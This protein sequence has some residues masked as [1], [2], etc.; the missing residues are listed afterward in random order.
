MDIA[1]AT[2]SAQKAD[3]NHST[4]P[5]HPSRAAQKESDLVNSGKMPGLDKVEADNTRERKPGEEDA[6]GNR[7]H[8]KS[9]LGKLTH[10]E[11]SGMNE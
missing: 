5:S 9:L 1:R 10:W 6:A 3:P 2:V 4:H 11:H 7:I 8:R